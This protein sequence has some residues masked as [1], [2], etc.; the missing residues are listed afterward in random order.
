MKIDFGTVLNDLEGNPIRD[1]EGVVTLRHICVN[2]L[3]AIYNDEPGLS[4]TDKAK[5]YKLAMRLKPEVCEVSAEEVTT[6]KTL[7][8]KAYAPLVVG[9]AYEVLDP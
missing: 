1:G 2:A 4:G 7:V 9:R 3:F 8:G 6:L 5:R